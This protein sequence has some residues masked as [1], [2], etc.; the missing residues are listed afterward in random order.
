MTS[1][2]AISTTNRPNQPPPPYMVA[3]GGHTPLSSAGSSP[4]DGSDSIASSTAHRAS[5]RARSP[6]PI[7][8]PDQ[9]SEHLQHQKPPL[10]SP[11]SSLS[12]V[13][14]TTNRTITPRSA[15]H[16]YN[17]G[18]SSSGGTA[19]VAPSARRQSD[20]SIM[21]LSRVSALI[22]S[23]SGWP[24]TLYLMV[25]KSTEVVVKS[26]IIRRTDNN[27][28]PLGP[29]HEDLFEIE[30]IELEQNATTGEPNKKMRFTSNE[31]R[32]AKK[33]K[34]K[35]E[36]N[37]DDRLCM[38][39]IFRGGKVKGELNIVFQTEMER[40]L[41]VMFFSMIIP[42]STRGDDASVDSNVTPTNQQSGPPSNRPPQYQQHQQQHQQQYQHQ[43]NPYHNQQQ[44]FPPPHQ[45][46]Y[47]QHQQQQQHQHPNASPVSVRYHQSLSCWLPHILYIVF[48]L[49]VV[50]YLSIYIHHHTMFVEVQSVDLRRRCV[51]HLQVLAVAF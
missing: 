22:D 19:L 50:S 16:S 10:D 29:G 24:A 21:D 31:I 34:G 42:K 51:L 11:A 15:R 46:H 44:Q 1:A 48:V 28:S 43:Q 49:F 18:P 25:S 41:A 13:T 45:Q 5:Y 17:G 32:A 33:G 38:I 9:D 23:L 40:D 14:L 4:N 47:Q 35:L 37:R 8:I 6:S 7:M 12:S 26:A 3:A 27:T 20:T 2:F 36:F 30:L 39:L